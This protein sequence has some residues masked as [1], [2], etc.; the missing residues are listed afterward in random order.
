MDVEALVRRQ[1]V[2]SEEPTVRFWV[3]KENRIMISITDAK[4]S[5]AEFVLVEDRMVPWPV[6]P[7][8]QRV[9]TDGFEAFV[10]GRL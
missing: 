9:I 10:P 2:G 7:P 1:I 5:V 8:T 3:N 6:K 4:D